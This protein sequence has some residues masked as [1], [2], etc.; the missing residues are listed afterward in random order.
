MKKYIF[1]LT[2]AGT[3]IAPISIF[4]QDASGVLPPPPQGDFGGQQLPPPSEGS[5]SQPT[6]PQGGGEPSFGSQPPFPENQ[7]FFPPPSGNGQF[8]QQGGFPPQGGQFPPRQFEEQFQ[9]GQQGQ[10]PGGQFQGQPQFKNQGKQP[11]PFF[12]EGNQKQQPT[13]FFGQQNRQG[14]T[15]FFNQGNQKQ[16]PTP[17]FNQEKG[18]QTESR[19][20]NQ[21]ETQLQNPFGNEENEFE[22]EGEDPGEYVDPR[23]IQQ[24]QKQISDLKR[25][26]GQL[27][28]KTAKKTTLA[29]ETAE[30]Q[31]FLTELGT[32]AAGIK[33]GSREALQDFYDAEL[34]EKINVW[35]AKIEMPAEISKMEKDLARLEKLIAAKTFQADGV[36]MG[37][38]RSKI[39]E[40]KNAVS[41]AKSA[42]SEEDAEGAREYLQVVYEGTHPGEMYGVLQQLREITKQLKRIKNAEIKQAVTE[43][44]SPAY[45]AISAGDFREAN[46]ALSEINKELFSLFGKLRRSRTVNTDLRKK[47][48]SLEQKLEGRIQEIETQGT[49]NGQPGAFIPYQSSQ[50][51]SAIESLLGSV[52]GFLGF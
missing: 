42:L 16:Q 40:V 45:E 10:F 7:G 51:A 14:P 13:P 3:L 22:E 25:Q 44:I 21:G 36:D 24:A 34:W 15:P 9:N 23:E 49:T 32:Y 2:L 27:L 29:N 52:K 5:F 8:P 6:Q 47:M 18:S 11:T 50:S 35:R 4:A 19:G 26:A 31:N 43:V 17:F 48:Q 12:N 38:V 41:G 37:L 30:L 33:E 46:M 28:K 39:E 20:I 1:T